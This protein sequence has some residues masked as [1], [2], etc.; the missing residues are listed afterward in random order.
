[1]FT[2]EQ[3]S[4]AANAL[5][6]AYCE[7]HTQTIEY[8]KELYRMCIYHR[9]SQALEG[10]VRLLSG[11]VWQEY[12]EMQR[13]RK[14]KTGY[15]HQFTRL[16]EL[17]SILCSPESL[18]FVFWHETGHVILHRPHL[19]LPSPA[20]PEKGQIYSDEDWPFEWLCDRFAYLMV[21]K[22][23]GVPLIWRRPGEP[24][25]RELD[26]VLEYFKLDTG[27]VE[28]MRG[29]RSH[30]PLTQRMGSELFD[31]LI[32]GRRAFNENI[33]LHELIV[34]LRC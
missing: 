20:D 32:R 15:R 13:A 29:S 16:V 6:V 21:R 22:R 14:Q 23:F 3:C 19:L 1:M 33:G 31:D 25:G 12:C 26:R 24:E 5:C 30:W 9:D 18:E 10:R 17:P 8:V 27:V 34:L 2:P 7:L 11:D 4:A 28:L